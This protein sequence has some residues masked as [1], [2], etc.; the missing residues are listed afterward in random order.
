MKFWQCLL[1]PVPKFHFG[2]PMQVS[3]NCLRQPVKPRRR[4]NTCGVVFELN[5][6]FLF[7]KNYAILEFI[8]VSDVTAV[9][10]SE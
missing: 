1:C 4:T 9:G 10:K 6:G 2:T 7:V 3:V 8:A 5:N